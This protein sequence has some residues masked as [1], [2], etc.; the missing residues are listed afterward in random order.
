MT[1]WTNQSVTGLTNDEDP[2]VV[3]TEMARDVVL[4]AMDEGWTG[5]PYDP[6]VLAEILGIAVAPSDDVLDARVVA[7]SKGFLVEY[8]PSR[9]RG[10]MRFSVAH[11]IAHTLFP[12]C[13]DMARH[14]LAYGETISDDWQLEL[15]CNVAAAEFLMPIG[16]LKQAD[17]I[18]SIDRIL[19]MHRE[20]EVSAE[21]ILLRLIKLTDEPAIAFAASRRGES[22]F[23]IDYASYSKSFTNRIP[24]GA[25]LTDTVL[26]GCTAIGVTS[27]GRED[28]PNSP[29][30][31]WVECVA[32]PPFPGHVH[33]RVVGI[34]SDIEPSSPP[35]TS[36]G[37]RYVEKDA[38]RPIDG[39]SKLV[40]FLVNDKTKRWGGGFASVVRK[41]WPNVQADF[42]ESGVLELGETRLCEVD[43]EIA[44]VAL[45]A[46]H[47]YGP[48]RKPRIRYLALEKSLAS[49]A[50][51]A[52]SRRA[53][54][55][56]PKIGAG[57]AGGSWDVIS[58]LIED[59][60]INSGVTVTVYSRPEIS[61][62]IQQPALGICW[63]N[64]NA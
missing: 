29:N 5:P 42:E 46:Q 8:N 33:P 27:R 20:F 53:S 60:L 7:N 54:V 56:L 64:W 3:I 21:A 52:I 1:T 50:K 2:I 44:T 58:E 17:P 57:Q 51:L 4:N 19:E 38:L 15:L 45:V 23:V 48:S 41:R 43:G 28:W 55:H 39:G 37:I 62:P 61:Q 26:S 34:A 12:D 49:L 24:D 11:E 36:S 10:R 32:I 25:R 14:R 40:A 6:F 30:P 63:T 59:Q 35:T 9:S 47:G 22:G 16:A 13:A 18:I 31:L